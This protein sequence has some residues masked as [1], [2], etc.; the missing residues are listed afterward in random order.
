MAINIFREQDIIVGPSGGFK[1]S[2]YCGHCIKSNR[3]TTKLIVYLSTGFEVCLV[4]LD[5]EDDNTEDL[6]SIISN[7]IMLMKDRE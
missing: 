3:E 5:S 4:T 2:T 1:V 6:K 7:M